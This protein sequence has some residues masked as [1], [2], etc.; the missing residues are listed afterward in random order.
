M[1][2]EISH[3]GLLRLAFVGVISLL[4]VG[5]A[6]LNKAECQNA[7]W[8]IIG[9]EDGSSGHAGSRIGSHRK[10]CAKHNVSPDVMTYNQGREDGLKEFCRPQRGYQVGLRG[11]RYNGVCAGKGE[12]QFLKAYNYGK[13]IYAVKSTIRN[14]QREIR[15]K[16]QELEKMKKSLQA[17]E[18]Q[19]ISGNTPPEKRL[20]LLN[21]SKELSKKQGGLEAEIKKLQLEI[22]RMEGNAEQLVAN[23]RY[24]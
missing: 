8:R 23:S 7:D 4:F 14:K 24:H 21:E 16:E 2:R 9:Y 5:C 18:Q 17:K 19:L 11:K 20:A 15:S 1:L 3:Y 6:S 10:A 12:G 13:K 22:A